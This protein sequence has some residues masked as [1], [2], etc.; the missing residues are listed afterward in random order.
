MSGT[1]TIFPPK[2][3]ELIALAAV[4]GAKAVKVAFFGL[5][6]SNQLGFRKV[7]GFDTVRL[8]NGT[9]ILQFHDVLL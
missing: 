3:A 1:Q 2:A 8:G 9:Y 5:N 7:T 4:G 6:R